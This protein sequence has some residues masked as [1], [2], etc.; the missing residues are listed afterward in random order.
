[1]TPAAYA[2]PGTEAGWSRPWSGLGAGL[3]NRAKPRSLRTYAG[4]YGGTQDSVVWVYACA[5]RVSAELAAY[6][7]Q[8]LSTDEVELDQQQW[9]DDLKQLLER[10]NA[11]QTWRGFATLLALDLELSG[12]SYWLKDRPNSLGQP[13]ELLRL[14]PELVK[15][16]TDRQ[17]RKLGYLYEINGVAVPYNL[18]EV[19][20]YK[21]ENPLDELYGMGK[22]E[23][24]QRSLGLHIAETDHIAG[25]FQNGGRI[26]GV[27]TTA[28][29]MSDVQWERLQ[30]QLVD[31]STIDVNGFRLLLLE[32]GNKYDPITEAPAG[33]GVIDLVR[34]S[35]DEVLGGFGVP[36]PLLGGLMENANY[37]M[38]DAQH[39]FARNMQPRATL[40]GERTTIDLAALW[41]L[42]LRLDVT[43]VEPLTVRVARA[44]E[45]VGSGASLNELRRAQDLPAV[46][47]PEADVPLLI[48]AIVPWTQ[49]GQATR[50]LGLAGS[51]RTLNELRAEAGLPP[52]PDPA[53]EQ[54]LLPATITTLDKMAA[55][56]PAF[57]QAGGDQ[58]AT[59]T[60]TNPAQGSGGG[61]ADGRPPEAEPGG[62]GEQEAE[63]E[64]TRSAKGAQLVVPDFGP[65]WEQLAGAKLVPAAS[66]PLANALLADKARVLR[67]GMDTI[68]PGMRA[69]FVE[70]RKRIIARLQ[71]QYASTTRTAV[72]SGRLA[73]KDIDPEGLWDQQDEDQELLAAYLGWVDDVGGRTLAA[74]GATLDAQLSWDLESP[75]IGAARDQLASLITRVNETTRQQV[76]ATVQEGMRRGYSITQIA[77]GYA[78]E[79]YPGIQGVFDDATAARAETIARSETAMI[80]NAAANAGY[81][82]VGIQMVGVLDGTGD[83]ECA[84]ANGSTWTVDD[85]E[86]N[87]IGHPNCVRTFVPLTGTGLAVRGGG[88]KAVTIE[89]PGPGLVRVL[90]GADG[91]A[92]KLEMV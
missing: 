37:K 81:R 71:A 69:F 23:A 83:D 40:V 2:P 27:L 18:D 21:Y 33:S 13:F 50:S 28:T 1:M 59:T 77:N 85:A 12:N 42:K 41:G 78:D 67:H 10:P 72:R 29:A 79:G 5:D 73:K 17:G 64:G 92:A 34:M 7:V 86:A 39:I 24:L 65:G 15:I 8:L 58:P 87:P 43:Y 48:E 90:Y 36:D 75:N 16:A 32:Q 84:E 70:Q 20:H 26:S 4:A 25:F 60:N 80:Y 53:A 63:G 62:A 61:G 19:I 22:V 14:R 45:M 6:D 54:P 51:G 11:Q 89:V 91:T 88:Q 76:A 49:V 9:P 68:A 35:K 55:P 66:T 46:D 3:V 47:A 82:D 30:Q 52:L 57:A 31:D 38:E 74:L 44:K 56:A